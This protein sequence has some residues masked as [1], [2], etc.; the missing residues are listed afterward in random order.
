MMR[1]AIKS[2]LQQNPRPALHLRIGNLEINFLFPQATA[3]HP[4]GLS[5]L[6]YQN[7]T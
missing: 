4:Y 1:G 6:K 7:D 3:M 2:R 5:A